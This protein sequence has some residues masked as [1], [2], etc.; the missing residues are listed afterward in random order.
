MIPSG[1]APNMTPFT[2]LISYAVVTFW[3]VTPK[4]KILSSL[5]VYLMHSKLIL[6]INI[7]QGPAA[8]HSLDIIVQWVTFM[9][10]DLL[11][12]ANLVLISYYSIDRP[13]IGL[14]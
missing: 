2:V 11:P 8:V 7:T 6:F 9:G 4:M 10:S 14:C 13:I 5:T 3:A 1:C 12:A